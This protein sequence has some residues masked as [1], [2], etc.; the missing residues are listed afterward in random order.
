MTGSSRLF[1]SLIFLFMVSHICIANEHEETNQIEVSLMAYLESVDQKDVDGILDHY[2]FDRRGWDRGPVLSFGKGSIREFS[3]P[4]DL[5]IF[6]EKWI[7][8]SKYIKST[9]HIDDLHITLI[10]DGNKN[11]LYNADAT[12]HRLDEFG[13][14][15][16]TLRK[17]YY[18][19]SDK[20]SEPNGS[21]TSWKIYMISSI[22]IDG[23]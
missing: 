5:R 14:V 17:L 19:Q 4:D 13:K 11:R 16:K 8:S 21:W 12:I 22:D 7:T 2:Y 18:F 1:H 6:L 20:L 9:T 15:I 10:F 23:T 3:D